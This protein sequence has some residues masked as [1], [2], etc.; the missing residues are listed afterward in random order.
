MLDL[1][2]L[3]LPFMDGV[4][5]CRRN[6]DHQWW[7]RHVGLHSYGLSQCW[8]CVVF[9]AEST[10]GPNDALDS[11]RPLTTLQRNFISASPGVQAACSPLCIA[12]S[13]LP[14]PPTSQ[15]AFAAS[16]AMT[17]PAASDEPSSF[18]R[19]RNWQ[20][21]GKWWVNSRLMSP[22]RSGIADG[23][24]DS[25]EPRGGLRCPPLH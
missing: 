23:I 14:W 15:R 20:K 25:R 11:H 2:W 18:L 24:F 10:S 21:Y 4:W 3:L 1:Q 12:N 8:P 16:P 9:T 6:S 13:H 19:S 22:R 7:S 17:A 5:G